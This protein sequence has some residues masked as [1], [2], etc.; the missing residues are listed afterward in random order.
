VELTCLL[1][2]RRELLDHMTSQH[3]SGRYIDEHRRLI[4]LIERHM[5]EDGWRTFADVFSWIDKQ[6]FTEGY[7]DD[8]CLRVSNL[9]FFCQKGFF[10]GN[11]EIQAALKERVHSCG[12]LDLLYLQD[13]A[14]ELFAHMKAVGYSEHHIHLLWEISK[15]IIWLSR[16]ISWNSY[17]DIWA[18]YQKQGLK[19][20]YLQNVLT[21]LG[22]LEAFHMRHEMPGNIRNNVLCDKYGAFYKINPQYK[23]LV[24]YAEGQYKRRLLAE[25]T[26]RRNRSGAA[27]FLWFMECNGAPKL[28]MITSSLIYQYYNSSAKRTNGR[29]LTPRLKTFLET[30]IPYDEDCSRVV[31]LLPLSPSGRENIQYINE[32]ESRA[33][34]AVLTDLSNGLSYLTR[35]IGIIL[36]YTGLRRGDIANLRMNSVDFQKMKLHVIQRKTNVPLTLPLPVIVGNA[37]YDYCVKERPVS[38]SGYLFIGSHAPHHPI[39]WSTVTFLMDTIYEKAEIRQNEG[40]RRGF[41]IFRH[42]MA[43][44]MLENNVPPVVISQTLGHTAPESLDA[45]LYADKVHLK[46]CS[47]PLTSFP[48]F[49]EVYA[50]V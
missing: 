17:E 6:P 38:D 21:N 15:R 31:L 9:E 36:F 25:S 2:N 45:Y 8:R 1:A 40:D 7:R 24:E 48:V 49:E 30:C 18:W 23:S 22:I 41:H 27:S 34:I 50:S 20:N 46:E 4:D 44:K 13:Y 35:A 39:G 10:H 12:A 42:R 37:I 19:P 26:L 33:F 5:S 32:E 3:Y 11:G 29:G 28:S 43:T 16:T 14:D 47:L